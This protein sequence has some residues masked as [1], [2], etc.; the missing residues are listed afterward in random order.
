M[1]SP[2]NLA[3]LVAN[4]GPDGQIFYG[5]LSKIDQAYDETGRPVTHYNFFAEQCLKKCVSRSEV[6][7]T[8]IGHASG[9]G[10]VLHGLTYLKNVGQQG[11]FFVAAPSR[12]GLSQFV[13]LSQG[14]FLQD[15][16]GELSNGLPTAVVLKHLNQLS[17][18]KHL[19]ASIQILGRKKMTMPKQELLQVT[20]QLVRDIYA[21]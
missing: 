15:N 14:H 19:T 17:A 6:S 2:L 11:L 13:A 20:Q 12:L 10:Q 21:Q 4:T 5:R 3:Q 16:K 18:T 9:E 1:M 7:M 8:V